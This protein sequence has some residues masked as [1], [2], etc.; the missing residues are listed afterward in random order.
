[1]GENIR[2]GSK[3]RYIVVFVLVAFIVYANLPTGYTLG[4]H[5]P[6]LDDLENAKLCAIGD[7]VSSQTVKAAS[8]F[9]DVP[10]VIMAIRR[11]GCP[12][13]RQQAASL[14]RL[15]DQLQQDGFPIRLVG[16]IHET[17][18]V[19]DFRPYFKGDIYYDPAKHFFG[20]K[21]RWMPY[22]M[23]FLR[24]STYINAYKARKVG[25]DNK[26][27]TRLLGGVFFIHGDKMVYGYLEKYWGD[28]LPIDQ[29]EEAIK[30]NVV[31]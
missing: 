7:N 20:P 10:V 8:I 1:M 5:M 3:G 22:W 24:L 27:E 29:L 9:K 17:I 12:F 13:C 2:C 15:I 16:I 11:T 18:G 31:S 4:N 14:S 19:S 21:Q 30:R 25:G 23:G 28:H 6:M 26:G